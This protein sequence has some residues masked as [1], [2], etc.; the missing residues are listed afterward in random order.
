MVIEAGDAD[1]SVP[2]RPSAAPRDT[3]PCAARGLDMIS[4]RDV[5]P[6][7][8]GN[9]AHHRSRTY[10]RVWTEHVDGLGDAGKIH[11]MQ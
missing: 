11:I 6:N 2:P 9:L 1:G 3:S 7:G 4:R 10:R 5:M 8:K